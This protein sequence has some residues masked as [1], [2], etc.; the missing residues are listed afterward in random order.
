MFLKI[1]YKIYTIF[2]YINICSILYQAFLEHAHSLL[3][4]LFNIQVREGQRNAGILLIQVLKKRAAILVNPCSMKM[5][6]IANFNGEAYLS[7][8]FLLLGS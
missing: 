7:L 4:S 8:I 1:I 5:I 2:S 3:F 6:R